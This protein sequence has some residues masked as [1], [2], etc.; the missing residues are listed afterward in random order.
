MLMLEGTGFG[1]HFPQI[2]TTFRQDKQKTFYRMFR[3]IGG[4]RSVSAY[5]CQAP[6]G[7][8]G[9]GS[10]MMLLRECADGMMHNVW[11]MLKCNL[12]YV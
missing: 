9:G 5:V 2:P 12:R 7:F 3:R 4:G 8:F 11:L 10:E 6:L 1:T